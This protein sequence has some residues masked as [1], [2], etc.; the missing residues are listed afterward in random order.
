MGSF[1]ESDRGVQ[2]VSIRYTEHLTDAGITG[3]VGSKA[4]NYHNAIAESFN[5]LYKTEPI[6]RRGPWKNADTVEWATLT[7]IDWFNNRPLHGEIGMVP[8]AEFE[9]IHYGHTAATITNGT[10]TTKSL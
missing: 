5:G 2:F 8:L 1:I 4:D 6:H 7:Y 10:H 9:T 3:S